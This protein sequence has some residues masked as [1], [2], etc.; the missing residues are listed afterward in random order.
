MYSYSELNAV[1]L[2]STKKD[3]YQI[4]TELLETAK[5]LSE[6]W[7]PT[8]TN[9]S[10]PGIVLLKVLTAIADKLNYSIDAN[11]M[12]AFMPS[13]AQEASMRKLCEMLGYNMRYFESATTTARIIYTGDEFPQ[14]EG[15]NSVITIDQFTNLKDI[16]GQINY[17]TLQP[18][19]LYEFQT[20]ET[21]PCMEGELVICE[22][23]AGN[24]I[25]LQNLD[26]N[27]RYYLPESQVATNG[28]FISNI[29]KRSDM[30]SSEYWEQTD[31]LN[32][33]PLGSK[34]Y[35]FG[36]DAALGLPYIEFPSDIGSLIA[37]GLRIMFIR[38]RGVAGNIATG[39]LG[40][41]EKPASW[42]SATNG[43]AWTDT[44]LYTVTNIAAAKNGKNPETIDEAYWNY[45]KTIGTFDTLVSCRDYMNKI[46]QLETSETDNTPLVSNI[47]VS[48]IRD[49]INHAYTLCTLDS[50]NVEYVNKA[51]PVTP[52]EASS[53]KK[54]LQH[55]ELIFYPFKTVRG[56]NNV[57][58]Y[59]GS[60]TYTDRNVSEIKSILANS[61]STPHQIKTPDSGDIVCIKVY[62]RLD[63]KISTTY[64]VS[65]LEAKEIEEQVFKAIYSK[66]NMRYMNFGEE[67]PYETILEAILNADP[68]IKNATLDDPKIQIKAVTAAGA[69]YL[70]SDGTN[71][72]TAA[73]KDAADYYNKLVLNNVLA[74]RVALFNYNTDFATS[75]SETPADG[76][77]TPFYI[78][79]GP[80]LDSTKFKLENPPTKDQKFPTAT[81]SVLTVGGNAVTK[82]PQITKLE[83]EFLV[84]ASQIS[85]SNP[86]T[87][88]QNEVVQ[89][90]FPSFH[91]TATY[92]AYVNYFAHLPDIDRLSSIAYPA[93]MYTVLDFFN[94]IGAGEQSNVDPSSISTTNTYDTCE[95]IKVRGSL[96][97][98]DSA[99]V[100]SAD[101]KWGPITS[102]E[103][104]INSLASY[105]SACM[106]KYVPQSTDNDTIMTEVQN[107]ASTYYM[108]FRKIGDKFYSA[109]RDKFTI[110]HVDYH[111]SSE[112]AKAEDDGYWYLDITGGQS[113]ATNFGIFLNWL[114]SNSC[115]ARI[116]ANDC[117]T[118]YGR[119]SSAIP[120]LISEAKANSEIYTDYPYDFYYEGVYKVLNT[121]PNNQ[122]G[123][124]VDANQSKYK[125]LTSWDKT[126]DDGFKDYYIPRLWATDCP[127]GEGHTPHT[128]LGTGR[129][130]QPAAI[131]KN[132]EY[133]LQPGE[134]ILINYSSSEGQADGSAVPKNVYLGPNTIIKTN[135]DLVDSTTASNV[136]AFYK[137][138]NYGPWVN[139]KT[140]EVIQ[141]SA[142]PGMFALGVQEQ[143]EIREQVSVKLDSSLTNVYWTLLNEETLE[144]DNDGNYLFPI[145]KTTGEYTLQPGEYLYITD[146]NKQDVAYYG[147]G[148][149]IKESIK[150]SKTDKYI[151]RLYKPKSEVQT[152]AAELNDAG[153]LESIPWQT[154]DLSTYPIFVNEYQYINLAEGDT[155]KMLRYNES[156]DIIGNTFVPVNSDYANQVIYVAGGLEAV[157]PTAKVKDKD[158]KVISWEVATK[159]ELNMSASV[160]QVLHAHL[161][162]PFEPGIP[163]FIQ[164]TDDSNDTLKIEV[165]GIYLLSATTRSVIQAYLSPTEDDEPFELT[166][167]NADPVSSIVSPYIRTQGSKYDLEQGGW[168]PDSEATINGY[169]YFSIELKAGNIISIKPKD[170]TATIQLLKLPVDAVVSALDI[171]RTSGTELAQSA[172]DDQF[173]EEIPLQIYFPQ[174]DEYSDITLYANKTIQS[175]SGKAYLKP[176]DT[177][178]DNTSPCLSLKICGDEPLI[179]GS[180][181]LFASATTSKEGF[182]Q[183]TF[184]DHKNSDIAALTLHLNIPSSDYFGLLSF[185]NQINSE[186]TDSHKLICIKPTNTNNGVIKLF[187]YKPEESGK[188]WWQPDDI[189]AVRGPWLEAFTRTTS[190]NLIFPA[191]SPERYGGYD[192]ASDCYYLRPGLNV[193]EITEQT[194]LEI[195]AP[196]TTID[197]LFFSGLS[198]INY[199]SSDRNVSLNPRLGCYTHYYSDNGTLA[200]DGLMPYQSL[201]AEIR[202]LDTAQ[203][204]LYNAPI[205][206]TTGLELNYFDK[207]DT[208]RLAKHW[209]DSGNINNKFVVTEIDA[210][211]MTKDNHIAVSKFSRY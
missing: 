201:L 12:E 73:S 147:S 23:D 191:D 7:D 200:L 46:Y 78:G 143:I 196:A 194:D 84:D 56:L 113:K 49:D 44:A 104:K 210:D 40:K 169:P 180:G 174:P 36:L 91:T 198:L 189:E 167:Q 18:I 121:S 145:D 117:N 37:D 52:D 166:D 211:Y 110:N 160:P 139:D 39:A 102:W 35:K 138:S 173:G 136:T 152:S 208:L 150:D 184:A 100:E 3:F 175:P 29:V 155:V 204:F 199:S 115:P 51:R 105:N 193:I 72:D 89:F 97:A 192:E 109:L 41:L 38:T 1:E 64:K 205:D 87:L 2:S 127:G 81:S 141:P 181:K 119:T 83:S 101:A 21:V 197:N 5:K 47:I 125:L 168:L 128:R 157:L 19:C 140:K 132:T 43:G 86:L 58:E 130:T 48:D 144:L 209:F 171:I 103:E 34:V 20:S 11:T 63:S 176:I 165:D 28:I 207:S 93:T 133:Q 67:L 8:S 65:A 31:N 22:T 188:S 66:F 129:S 183:L 122:I 107:L 10:D 148:S 195:Y 179:T 156:V 108:L 187:N 126:L 158:G 135:F 98:S 75:L 186:A 76:Y 16:D 59:T 161:S 153:L 170:K 190:G 95:Q 88:T 50:N 90:R 177:I 178:V 111:Y 32:L 69:E 131:P 123:T 202:K 9:E 33:H 149:V 80:N 70:L 14:V 118:L 57:Y 134:Y 74:G 137:T 25:T 53:G 185:Y 159:L 15:A 154:I 142:I 55:F 82:L 30:A 106:K 77:E 26:D 60:F 124:L 164:G 162:S 71:T 114:R 112:V 79:N 163:Y 54:P 203:K 62:F 68:R 4:W 13:A 151:T 206:S 45:Q 6:R 146:A 61:K 17:V 24:I 92:P 120:R 116:D 172:M 42:S 182:S 99:N 96:S 27:F 85:L 94:G